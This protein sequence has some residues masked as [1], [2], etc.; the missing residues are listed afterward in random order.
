MARIIAVALPK[1]GVGKTTTAV[2]LAA[3]FALAGHRTLLIDMDT[4][5]ASALA[6]G[7]TEGTIRAGL[8]E[9]FNFIAGI[10]TAIHRTELEHLDF[11]PSN[12]QNLQ[13]EDRMTRVAD[14]RAVLRNALRGVASQYTYIVLDCPPVLRGLCANALHA[15][16]SVLIPVRA[17]HFALDA[18]D[19]LFK[20]ID[21]VREVGNKALDVEGILL[22]MHEPNTKVAD[23]SVRELEGK[24]QKYLLST[25][26]PRNSALSEASFYGKPAVTYNSTSRG[27][28]AYLSLARDIA[29]RHPHTTSTPLASGAL[30]L[31]SHS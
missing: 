22:T 17:G 25:S 7:F 21:Y 4:F 9:V 14:N 24:Y 8:Y 23:I 29:A 15:A 6:L 20:Y 11:I 16:D 19:R 30:A 2:N 12:V 13:M 28:V 18:V 31:G 3:G 27:S 1:G 10:Q 26:I 5:G